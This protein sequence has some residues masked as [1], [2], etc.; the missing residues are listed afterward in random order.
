M[1]VMN[2]FTAQVQPDRRP[3]PK[4]DRNKK[5]RLVLL[6]CHFLAARMGIRGHQTPLRITTDALAHSYYDE[7]ASDSMGGAKKMASR[8]INSIRK[9]FGL[10]G[11]EASG[12]QLGMSFQPP[13]AYLQMFKYWLQWLQQHQNSPDTVLMIMLEGLVAAIES[14]FTNDPICIPAL[15]NE[16]QKRYK[17][18]NGRD[19]KRPLKQLFDD[20][21]MAHFL[22]LES[23]SESEDTYKVD[24]RMEPLLMRKHSREAVG[25]NIDDT[26]ILARP[27]LIRS[28]AHAV[29]K[30]ETKPHS[31]KLM[32][33]MKAIEKLDVWETSDKR[34]I[35]PYSLHLQ[36]T[37]HES[38]L[39]I[40]RLDSGTYEDIPEKNIGKLP[41]NNDTVQYCPTGWDLELWNQW[42]SLSYWQL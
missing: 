2:F 34:L 8:D 25:E 39:V 40:Y 41:V 30:K 15:A 32:L 7:G 4:S 23:I 13:R 6:G 16:L 29:L 24:I 21:I 31:E 37:K 35:I 38:V 1:N 36:Q 28:Q 9:V 19:A 26:L 11:A 14:A 22:P 3:E 17:K 5:T 27:G 33:I 20:R 42:K 12:Y 10:S 18:S